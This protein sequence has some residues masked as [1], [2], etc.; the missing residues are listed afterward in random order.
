MLSV[1]IP[2]FNEEENIETTTEVIHSILD[3]NK[4]PH[5]LIFINDGSKDKTWSIIKD[6]SEKDSYVKGINFSRNFGKEAAIYY[7]LTYAKGDCSAVIDCD[8]QHPPETLVEMYRLWE[9][10]YQI[11][12][13]VKADRGKEGIIYK[14]FSKLFYRIISNVS[15]IDLKRASDFKLLD[16]Q[17]VDEYIAL[18]ERNVFFRALSS[19]LGFRSICVEYEVQDRKYGE[20]KWSF[21]SLFSYAINNITSFS[22]APLQWITGLGIVTLIISIILGVQ[23]LVKYFMGNALEGFTTVIL[24]NLF[25]G[26]IVM[27]CLGIIGYYIAKIYDEIKQR[28]K[29]IISEFTD[30]MKKKDSK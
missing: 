23:S 7:G 6:L 16:K 9:E 11:I 17:V 19:W 1:I 10:G 5:E 29:A 24:I 20:S 15:D 22:S 28:P 27:I 3:N 30:E 8:L 13:G 14:L 2:A 26:S 25:I 21:K 18:P 4:I 12:E